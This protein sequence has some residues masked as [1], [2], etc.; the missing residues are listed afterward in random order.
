MKKSKRTIK[1]KSKRKYRRR[2]NNRKLNLRKSLVK[3]KKLLK[4]GME[5]QKREVTRDELE[6]LTSQVNTRISES[7]DELFQKTKS[8]DISRLNT[9]IESIRP[10][11]EDR[12]YYEHLRMLMNTLLTKCTEIAGSKLEKS[13]KGLSAVKQDSADAQAARK[14]RKAQEAMAETARMKA[15]TA[16]DDAAARLDSARDAKATAAAKRSLKA[17]QKSMMRDAGSGGGGGGA[18]GKSVPPKKGKKHILC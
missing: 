4:G 10:T 14:A 13:Q 6:Q 9:M 2:S 16:F 18:A 15:F 7:D 17:S 11:P 1:K 8:Q 12:Q 5:A 3:K